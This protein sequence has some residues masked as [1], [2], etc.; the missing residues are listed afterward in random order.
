M[1]HMG[2]KNFREPVKYVLDQE[3]RKRNFK[4]QIST[5]G[6]YT[7]ELPEYPCRLVR[8]ETTNKVGRII[9]A[10]GTEL[11]WSQELIRDSNNKVFRIRTNFPNG[12]YEILQ[13]FKDSNNKV[14][15]IQ[16]VEEG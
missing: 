7:G 5:D 2:F 11:E 1:S 14:S 6:E 10:E 4:N 8:D 3:L 12:A 16:V 13:L 15:N 9:Y